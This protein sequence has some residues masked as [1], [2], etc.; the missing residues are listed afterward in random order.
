MVVVSYYTYSNPAFKENLW[1]AIEYIVVALVLF[2]EMKK[3]PFKI[4]SIFGTRIK[5]NE[6][7]G[8]NKGA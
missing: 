5:M 4:F 2:N 8:V 6:P 3:M 1:L 7:T